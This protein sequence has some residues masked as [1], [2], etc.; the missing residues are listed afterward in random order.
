MQTTR[1]RSGHFALFNC[2]IL[3]HTKHKTI[4]VIIV[5]IAI[6]CVVSNTKFSSRLVGI[7]RLSDRFQVRA[8]PQEPNSLY[9]AN[10][11]GKL[12]VVPVTVLRTQVY[13]VPIANP[14]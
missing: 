5:T 3:G 9:G 1:D 7:C 10:R 12:P 14:L 13:S 2:L 6:T 11:K 4:I 8:R